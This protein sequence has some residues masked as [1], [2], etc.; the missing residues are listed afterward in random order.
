MHMQ[1]LGS[2]TVWQVALRYAQ[3]L[4]HVDP[5]MLPDTIKAALREEYYLNH[6]MI[7]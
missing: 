2:C 7:A 3:T 5:Q 4:A 1:A 6:I